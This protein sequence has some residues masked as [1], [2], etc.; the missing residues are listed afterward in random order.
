MSEV[1]KSPL[2]SRRNSARIRVEDDLSITFADRVTPVR[3]RDVNSGGFALETSDPVTVGET[4]IFDLRTPSG[5]TLFVRAKSTYCR[6]SPYRDAYLSGWAASS[7]R[8][9]QTLMEAID[10]V[11]SVNWSRAVAGR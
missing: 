4:R 5:R 11:T 9:K 6:K 2:S 7:E 10:T 1:S 3:V 8:T